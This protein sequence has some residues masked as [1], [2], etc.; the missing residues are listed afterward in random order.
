MYTVWAAAR[1][2]S[3]CSRSCPMAITAGALARPWACTASRTARKA[4]GN[5]AKARSRLASADMRVRTGA[6]WPMAQ[7]CVT[8]N[9]IASSSVRMA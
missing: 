4:C 3:S 7:I 6:E 9:I 2:A 1:Q 5:T 8:A